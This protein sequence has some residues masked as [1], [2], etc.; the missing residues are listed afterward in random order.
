MECVLTDEATDAGGNA[1]DVWDLDRLVSLYGDV[2]IDSLEY[3]SCQA[4][5]DAATQESLAPPPQN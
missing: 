2:C 3:E 5:D 4:V 1:I